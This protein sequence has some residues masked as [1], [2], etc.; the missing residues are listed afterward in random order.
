MTKGT[1]FFD[2]DGTLHDTM[3][4]YGPALRKAIAWLEH[5]GYLEPAEYSDEW[6]S[7]WLGWTTHDMWTTFA[8]QLP[9]E[10]WTKAAAMVGAEMDRLSENGAG[11]LFK[12]VPAIL[13]ELKDDGYTIAFLS[14]CRHA[15][16]DS[17]RRY[18]E[19]DRWIDVYHCAEDYPGAPK[20]EIYRKVA[21]DGK[22]PAPRIMV[23]DRFHDIEVGTRNGIP[24]IGCLYGFP[25]PGE[26]DAA[27]ICVEEPSQIPG[28]VKELPTCTTTRS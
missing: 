16:R 14:N 18:F 8:P 3:R 13:Q 24:T 5:E 7:H 21:E 19:L 28:A 26:L 25:T 23:G 2:Y 12:G 17:H 4:I 27:T 15:Y 9:E 6:I 11:A 1:I 22:H 10:V 20:W